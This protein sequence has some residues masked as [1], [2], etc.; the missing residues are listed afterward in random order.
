MR[1]KRFTK[2]FLINKYI[3]NSVL[4]LIIFCKRH[5]YK[6]HYHYILILYIL[7]IYTKYIE[8]IYYFFETEMQ[9]KL[10]NILNF[11]HLDLFK[12]SRYEISNIWCLAI[13]SFFITYMTSCYVS[14]G[15]FYIHFRMK[16]SYALVMV[17]TYYFDFSLETTFA[18]L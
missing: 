8:W 2:G 16:I 6:L 3:D 1:P 11:T 10:L 5:F 12:R 17:K 14:R 18:Y 9:D 7:E 4:L 15:E 13:T